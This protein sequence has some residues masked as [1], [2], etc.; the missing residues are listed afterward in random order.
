MTVEDFEIGDLVEVTNLNPVERRALGGT[1]AIANGQRGIV[2]EKYRTDFRVQ[3]GSNAELEWEANI[4]PDEVRLI[5]RLGREEA[6][7]Q[8]Y[9]ITRS[10]TR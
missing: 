3:R 4:R 7:A 1:G 9:R 2:T 6:T 5:E 8:L 10:N